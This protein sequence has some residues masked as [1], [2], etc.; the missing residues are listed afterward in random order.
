[1][2]EQR[3]GLAPLIAI[4]GCDG[5]GKSTVSE[6]ILI[7]AR[8]YGPAEAAHLGKQAGNV[9]RAIAD[10]PLVGAW[11]GRTIARKTDRTRKGLGEKKNPGLLPALVIMM[12]LMR[13][14]RRFQRMLALR[15]KGLIV[16]TDR[17]PQLDIPGAFDSTDLLATASGSAVVRWLARRELTAYQWMTSHRPDLVL[18]LN[19]DLDTACARKP[20][21]R[22]EVLSYKVAATP[23]LKF[24]GAPIVEI[25]ANRSLAEVL[26]D[27]KAAV[28]R[29]LEA[30]GYALQAQS[31]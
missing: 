26:V 7:W 20:D 3:A 14:L 25:D 13:R 30:R 2:P 15:R 9:G 12:F 18:R 19:V 8:R 27:A 24:N 28:A 11:A 23:L 16:V 31:A 29:V 22:R 1:M 10:W 6:E 4:V 21:H 17:Y 5:S